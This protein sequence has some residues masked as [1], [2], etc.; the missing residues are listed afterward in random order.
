MKKLCNCKMSRRQE[1]QVNRIKSTRD[2]HV[3]RYE[4]CM[5]FFNIV[6]L[7]VAVIFVGSGVAFINHDLWKDDEYLL[8]EIKTATLSL[9]IAYSFILLF[10]SGVGIYF[11]NSR[12]SSGTT[13]CCY[14]TILLFIVAIPLIIEGSAILELDQL[15]VE[16]LETIGKMELQSVIRNYNPI[17]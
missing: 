10:I 8:K 6:L 12:R 11:T 5:M 1:A 15:T 13:V 7:V 14:A 17:T 16:E 9:I 4:L 2:K 3:R